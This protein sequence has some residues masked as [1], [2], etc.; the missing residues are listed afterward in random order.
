MFFSPR[1]RERLAAVDRRTTVLE[2]KLPDV[3]E[4]IKEHVKWCS[5]LQWTQMILLVGV[6]GFLLRIVLKLG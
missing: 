1:D 3:I 4:T 5:K 6:C 2:T